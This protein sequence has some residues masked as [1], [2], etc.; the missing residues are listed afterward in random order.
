VDARAAL[1]RSR[2]YAG[3]ALAPLPAEEITRL[4][5]DARLLSLPGRGRVVAAGAT[6]PKLGWRL[7]VLVPL[8]GFA[9]T[10]GLFAL[11][12]LLLG[13]LAMVAALL[14]ALRSVYQRRVLEAAIRDP[15]TGLY[16]RMYM[17]ETVPRLVARHDRDAA[18]AFG[19]VILDVDFFKQV[20]DRWGHLAGDRVLA[21]LG[22]LIRAQCGDTD[23]AVRLGGEELAVFHVQEAPGAALRLA[24][25]LRIVIQRRPLHWEGSEIPV[26]VS[27]GVAEHR[28]GETLVHLLQRADRALYQAKRTGRNRIIDAA[29][30]TEGGLPPRLCAQFGEA[31]DRSAV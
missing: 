4:A 23:I 15:L 11:L 12:G 14:V 29:P 16:S 27:G 20:N 1:E 9:Q 30:P 24:E 26:T 21:E 5:P 18:A 2:A 31:E 19:V 7:M 13:L 25:R 17:N 8:A 22:A 3:E 6:L 28:A 10:V